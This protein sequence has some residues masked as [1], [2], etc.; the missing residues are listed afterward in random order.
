M[1]NGNIQK[2]PSYLKRLAE[3]YET[4]KK[5]QL[6]DIRQKYVKQSDITEFE[7]VLNEALP[8]TQSELEIAT[9]IK[10]LYHSSN[11]GMI[12]ITRWKRIDPGYKASK[13]IL[14]TEAAAIVDHFKIYRKVQLIWN[15]REYKYRVVPFRR[16]SFNNQPRQR[17]QKYEAFKAIQYYYNRANHKEPETTDKILAQHIEQSQKNLTQKSWADMVAEAPDEQ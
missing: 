12:N 13:F 5:S 6:A 7:H 4:L 3:C 16:Y 8:K 2:E 11:I 10:D 14:L 17:Q 15:N 9:A 1:E